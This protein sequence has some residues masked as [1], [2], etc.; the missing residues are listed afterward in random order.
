[1]NID[2]MLRDWYGLMARYEAAERESLHETGVKSLQ[3]PGS[4]WEMA[5]ISREIEELEA[6]MC[7]TGAFSWGP[8]GPSKR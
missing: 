2:S 8:K 7:G 4:S 1:M 5:A 6:A 3:L